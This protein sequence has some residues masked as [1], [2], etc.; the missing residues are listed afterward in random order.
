PRKKIAAA[1]ASHCGR[2]PHTDMK[3][4]GRGAKEASPMRRSIVNGLAVVATAAVLAMPQEVHAQA[5]NCPTGPDVIYLAGSTALKPMIYAI[6]P[7][8]LAA[9]TTLV[10]DGVRGSCDGVRLLLEN[11]EGTTCA[12]RTCMSG[13]DSVV[14]T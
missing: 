10:Y 11:T 2:V 6:G 4:T 12:G 3:R 7:K 8:A 14:F 1:L 13:A 9:G 5:V